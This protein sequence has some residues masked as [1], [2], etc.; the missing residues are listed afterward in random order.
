M[1]RKIKLKIY[2]N[3]HFIAGL[4]LFD[5]Q[6]CGTEDT[7]PG[8]LERVV[9]PPWHSPVSFSWHLTDENRLLAISLQGIQYIS[10]F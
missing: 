10:L 1:K 3:S 7:E 4:H 2:I 9:L 6:Y 5:I 8:I